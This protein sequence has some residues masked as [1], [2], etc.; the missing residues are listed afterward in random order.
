MRLLRGVADTEAAVSLCL[1]SLQ[2]LTPSGS[3]GD[4]NRGS[5]GCRRHD[6][7]CAVRVGDSAAGQTV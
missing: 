2:D 4:C 7:R 6:A 1:T 5:C 3:H